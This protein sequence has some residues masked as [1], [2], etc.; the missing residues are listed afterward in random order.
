MASVYS[1]PVGACPAMHDSKECLELGLPRLVS[2]S[3]Q[4]LPVPQ[5]MYPSEPP[6]H[7]CLQT[8]SPTSGGSSITH[9]PPSTSTSNYVYTNLE[10]ESE[11]NDQAT[12]D[13]GEMKNSHSEPVQCVHDNADDQQHMYNGHAIPLYVSTPDIRRSSS[14]HTC[15][16][17]SND[18]TSD[19]ADISSCVETT[20]ANNPSSSGEIKRHRSCSHSHNCRL[21]SKSQA[22]LNHGRSKSL[23]GANGTINGNTQ[24][25]EPH[26]RRKIM[27]DFEKEL[28]FKPK[29]ND[30][31]MKIAS[32][33]ARNSV[34]VVHRL[35]EARKSLTDRYNDR[36]TFVPKLNATSLKLAQERAT[37]MTEVK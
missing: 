18:H 37:R 32:R 33:N 34:P 30:Y 20:S 31:S 12:S 29:I 22:R 10:Y 13:H 35:L 9:T 8:Q 19:Q 21:F 6:V 15:V 23:N 2:S 26:C 4:Y 7:I 1:S 24:Q 3:Y 16:T 14:P 5:M 36:L 17:F 25:A 27:C 28:T 11:C